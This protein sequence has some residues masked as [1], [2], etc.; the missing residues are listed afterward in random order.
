M[1]TRF[2]GM[3]LDA[4]LKTQINHA[5]ASALLGI[6]ATNLSKGAV[7]ELLNAG[8]LAVV[9]HYIIEHHM[10]QF[11]PRPRPLCARFK[12]SPQ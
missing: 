3:E 12:L 4:A 8:L 7:V 9:E 1:H 2:L 11:T 6:K 5:L 10:P